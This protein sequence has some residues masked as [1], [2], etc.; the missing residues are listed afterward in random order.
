[1][2]LTNITRPADRIGKA[3][4]LWTCGCGT[5][6]HDYVT[7]RRFLGTDKWGAAKW[8]E[9]RLA[10]EVNGV[11][12]DASW[13]YTCPDC[14]RARKSARVQGHTTD[15]KCNAKCLASKGPVCECSCGGENHGSNYL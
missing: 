4:I 2:E 7:T 1:M 9:A 13:D 6:A 15:H 10:R 5:K 14:K 12:R 11:M 8:S 3:R